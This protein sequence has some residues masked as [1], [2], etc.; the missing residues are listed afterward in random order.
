MQHTNADFDLHLED[1][2][3][4]TSPLPFNVSASGDIILSSP[5]NFEIT[6]YYLFNVSV[7]RK[8][9]SASSN[10]SHVLQVI[11]TEAEGGNASA[12][13]RVNVKNENDL[14]PVFQ[15]LNYTGNITEGVSSGAFIEQVNQSE[16]HAQWFKEV[17]HR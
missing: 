6:E 2:L 17:D 4:S 3:N 14:I 5:L 8:C 1:I 7:M 9:L 13:V 16:I 12:Q 15:Q 11:A 10:T